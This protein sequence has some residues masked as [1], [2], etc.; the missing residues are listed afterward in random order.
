MN[1]DS[2]AAIHSGIMVLTLDPGAIDEGTRTTSHAGT[3]S[4]AG[5]ACNR[6][7]RGTR[8]SITAATFAGAR[9]GLEP[10]SA[11]KSDPERRHSAR[12]C[13]GSR[14][15][16][17]Q[18]SLSR[19]LASMKAPR[20]SS[21]SGIGAAR[22]KLAAAAD[23]ARRSSS[24]AEAPVCAARGET[25]QFQVGASVTNVSPTSNID[26]DSTTAW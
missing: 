4:G 18:A 14:W 26:I 6:D 21:L 3:D 22:G 8:C 15:C 7:G 25:R 10:V 12:A 16:A 9:A 13:F 5:L 20:V 2:P 23:V 11:R 1:T 19:E 17:R 24:T